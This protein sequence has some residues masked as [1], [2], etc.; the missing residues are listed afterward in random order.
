MNKQ[1]NKTMTKQELQDYYQEKFD[2][3]MNQINELMEVHGMDA[4]L[5]IQKLLGKAE[6]YLEFKKELKKS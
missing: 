5:T 6:A 2:S 4:N 3:I 1:N